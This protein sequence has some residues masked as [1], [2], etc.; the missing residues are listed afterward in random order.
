MILNT[1]FKKLFRIRE[2][3]ARARP[4]ADEGFDPFEKPFLD[5]LED[6]R[7]TLMKMGGTLFIITILCFAFH[8]Q[9]FVF[10]QLPAKITTL[11]DGAPL[12]ERIEFIVLKPPEVLIL[13]IKVSFF[14]AIVLAMPLLI[15]FGFQFILPG[16]R[17]V[18]KRFIIPGAGVGFLLFLLGASFAFFLASPIAL[19][20]FFVF[21]NE[22][23]GELDPAGRALQRPIA[24]MP[25][26]G[27][28]G[29][30]IPPAGEPLEEKGE[31][32]ANRDAPPE[33]AG[34]AA[35]SPDMKEAIRGYMIQL[36][37]VQEGRNFVLRYDSIRDKIVLAHSKGA[38]VTYQIGEYFS[39]ITRLTLVFGLSF[40]LPVI[41]TILVK[42]ELLTA[43]VMRATRTYAWVI[44]MVAA[45]ILTPPDIM[46]LALLAG[47]MIILYE[48]CVFIASVL[49]KRR[50]KRELAEEK[51]RRSRMEALYSKPPDDLSEEEKEEMHRHEIEQ[52]E[53]EHA[54][55]YEDDS[56]HD[57]T[58]PHRI[59]YD[60]HDPH[61]GMNDADH[62]PSW[63]DDHHYWHDGDD[64]IDP[65]HGTDP[66]DP[67]RDWPDGED[68][69]VG[70]DASG[71]EEPPLDPDD[72]CCEPDGP[73]VDL[74][75]ATIEEIMDLPGVDEELAQLI[76]DHRPY[77]TFDDVESLPEVGPERLSQ[78][79]ERLMLG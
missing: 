54:H 56:H 31:P 64:D 66:D 19:K 76:I 27:V 18:E 69:S 16:L 41:V 52:Y 40:Q 57:E 79:I 13:M 70:A 53:K 6:L 47:P 59:A 33:L 23:I 65:Q 2:E 30:R 37:A 12:W 4:G 63:H 26:L 49:E 39:F 61:H 62:D 38:M 58:D 10:L 11:E 55:L 17:Q 36:L 71:A 29:N 45:A 20:F 15:Y 72:E 44:I 51:K 60:P 68:G 7:H 28:G 43:R 9:I 21:Q 78:W 25:L 8:K 14:T 74:N 50:E 67:A 5:H 48:I 42:L 32:S 1:A 35:L 46:T 77:E 73:V 24:E 75:H 22:R 3:A 34:A